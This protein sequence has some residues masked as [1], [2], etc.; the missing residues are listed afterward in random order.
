M[1]RCPHCETSLT[2]IDKLNV[3]P[4]KPINCKQCAHKLESIKVYY[5]TTFF[6]APLVMSYLVTRCEFKELSAAGLAFGVCFLLFVCQ[7][8]RKAQ[9]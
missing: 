1:F 9:L 8:L 6:I 4:D 2:V 5:Y 3:S 7:P